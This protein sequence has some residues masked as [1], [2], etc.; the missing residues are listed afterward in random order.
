MRNVQLPATPDGVAVGAGAVW[1]VNGR[2][3]TLYRVDPAF[4][5]VSDG[6]RLG[7]RAITF[8]DAGVA[9]GPGSVWAAFGD[10]TLARVDTA[11]VRE[12]GL[13]VAGEGPSDVVVAFGSVWVSNSDRL[14]RAALQP[15]SRS[16][17]AACASSPS[18][19]ARPEW[20]PARTPSGWRAPKTTTSPGSSRAPSFESARTIPVGDGP[21]A[22]AVGEGSVWVANAADGTVSRIDPETNEVMKTITVGNAPVGVAVV[23]G[24]VWVSVQAP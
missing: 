18:A 19:D 12:T 22:V 1:V 8:T 13:A 16:R 2:L 10:S 15:D 4:D 21:R 6:L 3:G 14:E 20:L 24:S 23:D 17:K 9:V 7:E 5:R 11:P